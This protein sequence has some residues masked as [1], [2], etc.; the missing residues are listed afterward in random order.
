MMAGIEANID[1]IENLVSDH[2]NILMLITRSVSWK[3]LNIFWVQL[4]NSYNPVD[5]NTLV[6]S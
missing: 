6:S 3:T 2:H 4:R 5:G 1:L